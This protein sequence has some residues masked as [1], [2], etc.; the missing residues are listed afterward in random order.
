MVFLKSPSGEN[1]IYK[2]VTIKGKK[3]QELVW[4]KC[5]I[6]NMETG[7][8]LSQDI[9][10]KFRDYTFDDFYND[11]LN[12]T[13]IRFL[14]TMSAF[15]PDTIE[16]DENCIA[17]KKLDGHRHLLYICGDCNRVFSKRISKKTGWFKENTDQ[18][19][20]IRD[21]KLPNL[22]GTVL[23]GE[24]LWGENST[25]CQSVMGA[26]PETAIQNQVMSKKWAKSCCFDILYYK[27]MNVQKLPLLK[28]KQYLYKV[29]KE[30]QKLYCIDYIDYM[31][32]YAL[33][34]MFN[35]VANSNVGR[36]IKACSFEGLFNEL[37]GQGAEG[38][39]V[40]N[41]DGKYEQGKRS[42]AFSKMKKHSTW[43]CVFMGLTEPEREYTGK[44]L[45]EDKMDEWEYWEDEEPVTKP[46]A[47]GWCGG[48]RFGVWKPVNWKAFVE[49]CGGK[50]HAEATFDQCKS[51]GTMYKR[52]DVFAKKMNYFQL[53]EVGVA[54]GLTEELMI[55]LKENWEE[56][57]KE[58]RVV[59]IMA[60][61]VLDKKKG[62]LRHPRFYRWR[63]DVNHDVCTWDK[64]IRKDEDS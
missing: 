26:L 32:I 49:E 64:H 37:V 58:K 22:K 55:D 47:M 7:E 35:E 61:E 5:S 24:I 29:I 39:I 16:E 27:G 17:E 60:Q 52:Y 62:S 63:D 38:I 28:R 59:E 12:N 1:G 51:L 43:D 33:R 4:D 56:Y 44:K 53:V 41:L 40:K 9:T 30:I 36:V 19:P 54:K 46:Y 13:G 10:P 21:L 34:S 3:T 18:L 23:D 8:V 11:F 15:E 2:E 45:T 48:I 31:P 20:H 6:I 25:E 57:L 14:E 50:L 42:R